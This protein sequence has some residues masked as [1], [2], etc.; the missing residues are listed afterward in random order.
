MKINQP[1]YERLLS[2]TG[3]IVALLLGRGL[4]V[5]SGGI[6]A[7]DSIACD[8]WRHEAAEESQER[9]MLIFGER[10]GW[11]LVADAEKQTNYCRQTG[12]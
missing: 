4:P 12:H 8:L 3:L 2:M 7:P 1:L 11:D 9:L 10:Q 5:L 6:N